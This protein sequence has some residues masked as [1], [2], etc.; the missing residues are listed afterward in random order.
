MTSS[1]MQTQRAN[2]S[3]APDLAGKGGEGTNTN[4]DE[5]DDCEDMNPSCLFNEFAHRGG[6][7]CVVCDADLQEIRREWIRGLCI[8]LP[9]VG[10][11]R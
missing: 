2:V 9:G 6:I 3:E 5:L 4:E 7:L 8:F 1:A 10:I 11:R